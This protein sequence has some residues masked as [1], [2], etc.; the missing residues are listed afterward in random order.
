VTAIRVLLV[1][2]HAV[3]RDGLGALLETRD[4]IQVVGVAADGVQALTIARQC[5]PDT[6]LMDLAMP[7]MDGVEATRRLIAMQPGIAVIVL[8]MSDD[9]A[10]LLAAIRAGARGYL[11][12]DS[13]GAEVVGTIQAVSRGQVVFGPG[14]AAT[15]TNFLNAPPAHRDPPFK[16]LSSRERQI[17]DLVASGMTNQAIARRLQIS[18]KTVANVVSVILVKLGSTDRAQAAAR[19]RTAGLGGQPKT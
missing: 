13:D 17:L 3:V 4:D 11:L 6:V 16:E 2:D 15:I 10:S 1:D 5:R 14:I 19:A 12:K 7:R 9:D 18:A 8:T